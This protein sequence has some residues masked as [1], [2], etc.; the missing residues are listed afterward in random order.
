MDVWCSIL[1]ECWWSLKAARLTEFWPLLHHF[2]T[3]SHIH[4]HT[5]HQ[6]LLPPTTSITVGVCNVLTCSGMALGVVFVHGC[7]FAWLGELLLTAPSVA[8]HPFCSFNKLCWAQAKLHIPCCALYCHHKGYRDLT[9]APHADHQQEKKEPNLPPFMSLYSPNQ[10]NMLP[11]VLS[12]DPVNSVSS[13]KCTL[14]QCDWI[15]WK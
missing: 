8:I 5:Y 11:G 9:A 4:S 2:S 7:V 3:V 12:S 14:L 6:F 15:N 13:Q 1:E 10:T